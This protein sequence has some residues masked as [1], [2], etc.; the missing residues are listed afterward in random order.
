MCHGLPSKN[1]SSF[2]A[3]SVAALVYFVAF[4]AILPLVVLA[5]GIGL[6]RQARRD[7][8]ANVACGDWG[9]RHP[10]PCRRPF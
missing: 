8:A 4:S 7:A 9:E 10:R 1:F 5:T 3:L 6:H 2:F